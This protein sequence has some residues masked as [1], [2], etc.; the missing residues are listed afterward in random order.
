MA[1]WY[2]K[3]GSGLKNIA[4]GGDYGRDLVRDI[5]VLG[6]LY[7]QESSAEQ[8]ANDAANIQADYGNRALDLQESIYNQNR[9]D[10]MPW[11][12][13]GK[14][15]LNTLEGMMGGGEFEMAPE[16][17]GDFSFSMDD[18]QES[19]YAKFLQQ[20]G[21]RGI[22]RSAA[23]RGGLASG[24][25]LAGLQQRAMGISAGDYGDQYNRKM[26]EYNTGYRNFLDSYTRRAGQKQDKYN[27]YA[28]M[29]GTGQN[30]SQTLGQMGQNYGQQAGQG[31]QGIGNVYGAGA[32]GRGNASTNQMNQLLN[33]GG[34]LGSAALMGGA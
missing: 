32:I 25:T 26:G 1:K 5:P 3:A 30:Q 12:D 9:Q 15:S 33:I 20:E 11:L 14:R 17:Y 4:M 6:K 8:A 22:E 10:M 13:A 18:Y 2:E 24:N 23:A 16:E 34:Q 27:R 7:G 21:Q 19:P 31:L 29:A 28:G